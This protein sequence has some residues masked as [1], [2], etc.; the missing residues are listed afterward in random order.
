MTEIH[1]SAI[2]DPGAKI[3]DNVS[4]GPYC[5]IG[6]D[7]VLADKV[8]L[9]SH[10]VVAGRTKIGA[11]TEIYPFASIG[12]PPQDL[13]YAGEPSELVIGERN[14][15]REYTT[16]N[17]GTA[18]GGMITRVGNDCLLMMGVH[19]AH[20]CQIGNHVVMANNASLGGHVTVGDHAVF[21]A[22][23]GVHQF[24][25]IG[26]HAMIGGL[27][28]VVQDVIPYGSVVGDRAYLAGLN[29]TG[30]KRRGFSRG[31]I[32]GLRTAYRLLFAEEGTKSERL[33]DVGEMYSDNATVMEI[34]GFMSSDSHR[35]ICQPNPD[36]QS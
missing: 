1:P 4:I 20:D 31:D 19:V 11:E 29:I 3:A 12:H 30:L 17:P 33:A 7:V 8:V 14:R 9:H 16:A 28:A 23:A 36:Q 10:V 27:S 6:P 32:H 21:G 22:L 5:V 2:V 25:R 18:G 26:D 13:K 24:T 15:I 35:G 34:V